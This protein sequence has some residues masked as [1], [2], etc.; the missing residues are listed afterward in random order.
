MKQTAIFILGLIL[1]AIILGAIIK[2]SHANIGEGQ[3]IVTRDT[4]YDTISYR[5][6]IPVDSTVV[7]YVKTTL[8][9]TNTITDTM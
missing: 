8:Q 2:C 3:V 5:M 4:V 6:P 1:G 9:V 7:R